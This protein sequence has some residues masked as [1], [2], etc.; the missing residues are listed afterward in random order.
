MHIGHIWLLLGIIGEGSRLAYYYYWFLLLLYF[1]RYS[2]PQKTRQF[3]SS[4]CVH[5]FK[6][7]KE[8]FQILGLAEYR[9]RAWNK[10]GEMLQKICILNP[11][12]QAGICLTVVWIKLCPQHKHNT[13]CNEKWGRWDK[14]QPTTSTSKQHGF[15]NT[16]CNM[17]DHFI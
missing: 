4:H 11:D 17:S 16:F 13:K 14:R 5:T 7:Q 15:L 9:W 1:S 10:A 2:Q 6:M 8:C 12:L 3:L